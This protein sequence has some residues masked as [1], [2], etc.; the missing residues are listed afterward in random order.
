VIALAIRHTDRLAL[1]A[2][3]VGFVAFVLYG[4]LS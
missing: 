1:V 2:L 3:L 4:V